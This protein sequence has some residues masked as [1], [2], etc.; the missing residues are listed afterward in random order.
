MRV[1]VSHVLM[2]I[3]EQIFSWE[4]H[5]EILR[6][7]LWK[8]HDLKGAHRRDGLILEHL[9]DMERYYSELEGIQHL[10][11]HA[12]NILKAAS[13]SLSRQL[14]CMNIKTEIS[15]TL[16]PK[17]SINKSN[18]V[19]KRQEIKQEVKKIVDSFNIN[20]DDDLANM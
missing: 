12:D 10:A 7:K 15:G 13:E 3:F 18:E 17:N 16:M 2:S 9:M 14:S 1:R 19:P 5:L 4:R 8:D 20:S 6:A 11:Q